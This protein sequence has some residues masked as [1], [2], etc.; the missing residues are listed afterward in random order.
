MANKFDNIS[1][2]K[3]VFIFSPHRSLL[4][5][6][7]RKEI[8]TECLNDCPYNNSGVNFAKVVIC[9][10]FYENNGK[11]ARFDARIKNFNPG[12]K[13][14]KKR[15]TC[16]WSRKKN[17]KCG[18]MYFLVCMCRII[19]RFMYHWSQ[20]RIISAIPF[21][22][23]SLTVLSFKKIIYIFILPAAP[24][25]TLQLNQISL[26]F[27]KFN[28]KFFENAMPNLDSGTL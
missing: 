18:A 8:I 3:H 27:L 6:K 5:Q 7:N 12:L 28:W 11:K 23:C 16:E 2:K 19:G 15:N 14:V 22:K 24:D 4:H 17:Q 21:F 25:E 20:L 26:G 10:G 9:L 1:W 13:E